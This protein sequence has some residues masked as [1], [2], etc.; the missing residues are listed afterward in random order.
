MPDTREV[1]LADLYRSLFDQS[2]VGAILFDLADGRPAES[3]AAILGRLGYTHDELGRLGAA[4]IAADGSL[5]EALAR[6]GAEGGDGE[7]AFETRLLAR[8]GAAIEVAVDARRVEVGGHPHLYAIIREVAATRRA[9]ASIAAG[10]AR[11]RALIEEGSDLL[12]LSGPDGRIHYASPSIARIAGYSA[13]EFLA[14]HPFE[15]IHPDDVP[16]MREALATALDRPGEPIRVEHRHRHGDGT[17]RWIAGTLTNRLGEPQV[18][19]I[20][21]NFRDITDRKLAEGQAARDRALFERIASASPDILYVFDVLEDRTIYANRGLG[22]ALGRARGEAAAGGAAAD[23]VHPDD[24]ESAF[25][26]PG[27]FDGAPEGAVREVE[28]RIRGVD[29][30][31]RW[32]RGREV[33]FDRTPEGKVRSVLGVAR[34]V[35]DRRDMEDRLR[36]SEGRF[37]ALATTSASIVWSARDDGA[38]FD[39]ARSWQEFTG[40]PLDEYRGTGWLAM[41]HPDDRASAASAWA[42][43]VRLGVPYEAEYRVRRRDGAYRR[44]ADRGVPVRGPDGS[45]REWV[46]TCTDVTDARVVEAALRESRER[47][48]RL[49]ESDL[50]GINF[51]DVR[52]GISWANDAYLRIIGYD[53]E[54]FATGRVG[55]AELT[56]PEWLEADRRAIAEATARGSCTP[57]EKQYV[58]KDGSRIWVLVGFTFMGEGREDV[59]AFVLDLSRPKRAEEALRE[60]D[61]RKDEFLAMLAHEL[62]NPLAAIAAATSVSR[63]GDVD[64]E[65]LAWTRDVT[66][67]QARQLGRL[68]DDLLDVSRINSGKIRL[69]MERVDAS[70]VV[71]QAVETV[72]PIVAERA[73][74]LEV[75][76][77]PGPFAVDADP[78]RLEQVLV[79]LLNNASKYTDEGGRITVEARREGDSLRFAVRDTGIGLDAEMLPKVFDLF[80]Q[81]EDSMARSRGGL[82]IGLTLVRTL[83]EM[84]GGSVSARSDGPGRGSEFA[85]T[86]PAAPADAEVPPARRPDR[87]GTALAPGRRRVLVVDDS[88]DTARALDRLLTRS[89]HAVRVAHD[90]ESALGIALE[91]RPDV[92]LLD[93][94]LPGRDGY[95]VAAALRA[96]AESG[97]PTLIALSGYGQAH[98]LARSRDVG[99]DIHLVKPVDFDTLLALVQAQPEA[100]RA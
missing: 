97:R 14:V 74:T 9:G 90:G 17:W 84:H 89:G 36:A 27:E 6:A 38:C 13:D 12:S 43:A 83:A 39:D 26:G 46:G 22:E 60:A 18:A 94:G 66:D 28:Y 63:L 23:L 51:A 99:I 58:R 92:V 64:A 30:S 10:E 33:A 76:V 95:E 32:L 21:G 79:N 41:V 42:E 86:L 49:A 47:L 88:V 54:E 67:R 91:F 70:T 78:A 7:V 65:T 52:G 4:D 71:A 31:D 20:V 69:R 96:R 11:F 93:I 80:A 98:D 5:V 50:I 56:P 44:M 53:R 55:W 77:G 73:Q 48:G 8:S 1:E 68:V 34:D 35:T 16:A 61:R 19:A 72:R 87:N 75:V 62:R 29:G 59:V 81:V 40:Q 37:R 85:V 100:L 82:G 57:Y 15:R 2:P 24:R 45:I 3:N 25:G